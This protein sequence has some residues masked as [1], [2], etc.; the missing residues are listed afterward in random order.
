MADVSEALGHAR[1]IEASELR[2]IIEPKIHRDSPRIA[3]FVPLAH[4]LRN[5]EDV[6]KNNGGIERE[7]A[8]RL[9]GH[10]RGQF[11]RFDHLQ[12]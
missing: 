11:W 4:R 5:D 8:E 9:Q 3:K 12:E 6:R 10:F 1:A 7:T 2:A